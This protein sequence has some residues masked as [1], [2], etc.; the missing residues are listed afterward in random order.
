LWYDYNR[1]DF[2]PPV[3]FCQYGSKSHDL[4]GFATKRFL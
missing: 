4:V 1:L 2:V 3:I